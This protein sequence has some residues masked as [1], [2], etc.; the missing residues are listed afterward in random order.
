MKATFNLLCRQNS[1]RKIAYSR[2]R[3]TDATGKE[4]PARM[5]ILSSGG[6]GASPKSQVS[7]L[8]SELAVLVNDTDAVYPI[9][10]D[11][12]FSD[13]NWISMGV[14]AGASGTVRA[15]A[16]DA[17]GN[18]YVAG[19][20]LSPDFPLVN[21]LPA[22][23]NALQGSDTQA[24]VSKL[25]FD[26]TSATLA[27]AYSTFLGGTNRDAGSAVA[28]DS[29]GNAYVTGYTGAADFPLVDP[30]PAPNDTLK[31]YQEAFVAKI[32]P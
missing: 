2:L 21:P 32:A 17:W 9:R 11:P 27:L 13:A 30:L 14:S 15:A 1:G 22:P 23:N 12:T 6:E 20:A 19:R 18:A 25:S 31:G 7:N 16:V 26:P 3:V 8:K 10:I 28:V 24:F 29:E 5:E 4:L